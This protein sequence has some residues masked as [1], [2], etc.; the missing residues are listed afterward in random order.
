MAE[1]K[2]MNITPESIKLSDRKTSRGGKIYNVSFLPEGSEF[3][4]S[5]VTFSDTV[6]A[7]LEKQVGK[8]VPAE[9]NI[10]EYNGQKSYAINEVN[11][12][13][14]SGFVKGK[15]FQVDQ[16]SIERREAAQI[17]AKLMQ[18][19]PSLEGV[20]VP[21]QWKKYADDVYKWISAR[22]SEPQA[23]GGPTAQKSEPDDTIDLNN[24][25]PE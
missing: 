14:K 6:A 20:D 15:G 25:F 12:V 2:N 13:K 5:A 7:E 21:K 8:V 1:V 16:V 11:G 9:V 22:P 4:I 18:Y 3:S 10:S 19:M 24:I 17:A 23:T